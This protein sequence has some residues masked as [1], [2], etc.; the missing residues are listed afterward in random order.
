MAP[1]DTPQF[2]ALAGL[3]AGAV[4]VL[5]GPD[6]LAAVL[7][8][9]AGARA[10][11]A[12]VGLAWGAGHSLGVLALGA[13]VLALDARAAV[14]GWSLFA[15]RAVGV[16]LVALGVWA[17][18]RR[19]VVHTH[20]HA[21]DG[22]GHAHPH[23]HVGDPSVGEARHAEVGTHGRH[24]HSA[25]GFGVLHGVAGTSHLFGLLPALVLERAAAAQYLVAFLI[26][27][28]VAMAVFSAAAGALV[29]GKPVRV[30]WALRG[31][32]ALAIAV[33]VSWIAI[34]FSA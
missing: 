34:S 19:V 30:Q 23:V 13:I 14:E 32:G 27:S 17:L 11:A 9:S 28:A 15:E 7:P 6:H 8:F 26:G 33:G 29:G 2:A 20:A 18:R 1:V 5:T 31:S 10:R 22:D 3:A 4:H 16:L 21:H 24:H 12:G 25:L